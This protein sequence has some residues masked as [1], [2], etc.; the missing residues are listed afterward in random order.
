MRDRQL[1]L[2]ENV[3]ERKRERE[4]ER[5]R[6]SERKIVKKTANLIGEVNDSYKNI[7]SRSL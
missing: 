2:F 5:G 3:C 1:V 7:E 6:M 4:K